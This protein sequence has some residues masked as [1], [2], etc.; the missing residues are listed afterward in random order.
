ML[1]NVSSS[2][3]LL[4][5]TLSQKR[6]DDEITFTIIICRFIFSKFQMYAQF[7]KKKKKQNNYDKWYFKIQLTN[8]VSKWW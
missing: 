3:V 8:I 6:F 2:G 5:E 4:L 1:Y 7:K